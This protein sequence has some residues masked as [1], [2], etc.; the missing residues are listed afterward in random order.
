MLSSP[1]EKYIKKRTAINLNVFGRPCHT[2]I[3]KYFSSAWNLA[4]TNSIDIWPKIKG[5]KPIRIHLKLDSWGPKNAQ[6]KRRNK[7]IEKFNTTSLRLGI[8]HLL[9][10]SFSTANFFNQTCCIPKTAR[11]ARIVIETKAVENSPKPLGERFLANN[12]WQAKKRI[13]E[14]APKKK[15][16][17]A[18]AKI[19]FNE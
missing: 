7:H 10:F 8:T 13:D 12:N 11:G 2:A 6:Q 9:P 3:A 15:S 17:Y 18:P 19:F 16:G 5:D 14:S 1:I 4:E